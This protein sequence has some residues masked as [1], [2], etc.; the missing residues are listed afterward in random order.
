MGVVVNT[1]TRSACV[2]CRSLRHPNVLNI[3]GICEDPMFPAIITEYMELGSLFDL[4]DPERGNP[5]VLI[6]RAVFFRILL[7]AVRGMQYLHTHSPPVLHRDFKSANLLVCGACD[8]PWSLS[9][10]VCDVGIPVF[11]NVHLCDVS[12]RIVF[13]WEMP[14][15]FFPFNCHSVPPPAGSGLQCQSVRLW[16]GSCQVCRH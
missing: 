3:L 16:V 7:G 8:A 13:V 12:C 4:L 14:L 1:Y 10:R 2:S 15:K 9:F 11:G 6:R 5:N